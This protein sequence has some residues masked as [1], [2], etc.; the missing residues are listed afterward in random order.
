MFPALMFSE[1]I[2][3]TEIHPISLFGSHTFIW[4]GGIFTQVPCQQDIMSPEVSCHQNVTRDIMSPE[5][6]QNVTRDIMPSETSPEISC[7]QRYHITRIKSENPTDIP[8]PSPLNPLRADAFNQG[9]VS[10]INYDW[11][12]EKLNIFKWKHICQFP[13]FLTHLLV[14]LVSSLV[15]GFSQFFDTFPSW[16]LVSFPWE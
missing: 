2:I 13:P 5:C 1:I 4:E 15:V 6:H 8:A 3:Q 9:F 16:A 7:H 12:S 10:R 14:V 11:A